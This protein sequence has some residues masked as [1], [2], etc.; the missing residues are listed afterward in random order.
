[1]DGLVPS[2]LEFTFSVPMKRGTGTGTIL[3]RDGVSL[4][5]SEMATTCAGDVCS[6][7]MD[8]RLSPEMLYDVHLDPSFFVS[9]YNLSLSQSIHIVFG[10]GSRSCNSH[11]VMEGLGDNGLCSCFSD[12]DSCLC[13][14]GIVDVYRTL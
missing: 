9:E 6:I 2:L 7:R 1:M 11:F 14:C 5:L 10:T 13:Q 8:S 12:S 3:S 4:S